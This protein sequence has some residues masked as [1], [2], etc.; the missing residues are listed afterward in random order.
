MFFPLLLLAIGNAYTQPLAKKLAIAVQQLEADSQM[1]HA[2]VGLSVYDDKTGKLIY[3]HNAGLGLAPASTQKLF[4]SCAAFD[5]LGK[6]Y[7]YT[8]EIEY[9]YVR[10]NTAMG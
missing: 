5:L 7:K 9:N 10:N 1:H 8:T 2:I 3:E 4:T 6:D